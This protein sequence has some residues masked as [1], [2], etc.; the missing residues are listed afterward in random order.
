VGL[1]VCP[2]AYRKNHSSKFHDFL[3]HITCNSDSVRYIMYFQFCDDVIFP[4]NGTN[5][6]E[7]R[8]TLCLVEFV[9]WQHR[10]EIAVYDC[11]LVIG[12]PYGSAQFCT[13]SSVGVVCRLSS[14]VTRVGGR[15]P[16]GR[17]RGRSRPV[18]ATPCYIRQTRLP[19][20]GLDH[21][22]LSRIIVLQ[23]ADLTGSKL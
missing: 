13:L 10:R 14:F 16:P 1:S 23:F 2:L 12:A 11:R 9:R 5:R 7:S 18:R 19:H 4:H 17:A 22:V 8:T 21:F 6:P 15:P 3:L 20:A